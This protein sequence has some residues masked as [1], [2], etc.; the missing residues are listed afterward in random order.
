[1]RK[2]TK[3][4]GSIITATILTLGCAAQATVTVDPLISGQPFDISTERKVCQMISPEFN[5]IYS[6]WDAGM[7]TEVIRAFMVHGS[8]LDP[9]VV[10]PID[11]LV[12]MI[13]FFKPGE[14]SFMQWLWIAEEICVDIIGPD[15]EQ[16][17]LGP[18]RRES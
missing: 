7:P 3:V 10:Y 11:I 12:D 1:M 9:I 15:Y 2:L 17:Q 18:N 13:S 16:P 8:T 5:E 6:M 4:V 14:L